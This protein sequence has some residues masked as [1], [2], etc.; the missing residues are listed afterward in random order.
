MS[1]VLILGGR[2]GNIGDAIYQQLE[3]RHE[4]TNNDCLT[5]AGYQVPDQRWFDTVEPEHLIC[6]LGAM[7][8]EPFTTVSES[9]I[10]KVI[11]G[12]L[13]MPLIAARRFIETV[14]TGPYDGDSPNKIIFI[15]SYA[16]DHALSNSAAY[17]AA[18]AG[19][20]AAVKEL[21]WEL[22][23]QNFLVHVINPY[24]VPDTP[25]GKDVFQSMIMNGMT[26]VQAKQKQDENLKMPGHLTALEIAEMVE[27]VLGCSA[28]DWTAGTPINMYGGT[29]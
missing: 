25:M 28:M 10:Y 26:A 11:Y 18:K 1:K 16:H 14:Q 23:P 5:R 9:H 24:H 8:I 6:T 12:S 22:T 4:V 21:A 20:N 17:C 27:L 3:E 19:L 7:H 29:R 2:P 13:L 15:G